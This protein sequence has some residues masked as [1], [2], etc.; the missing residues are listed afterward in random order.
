VTG[1]TGTLIFSGTGLSIS[2]TGYTGPT[3][4][5]GN[6]GDFYIDLTNGLLYGPKS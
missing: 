4:T 5:L 1:P 3:G 2:D 6:I